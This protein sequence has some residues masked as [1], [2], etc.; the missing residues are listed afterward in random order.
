[1]CISKQRI[2]LFIKHPFITAKQNNP[3][4]SYFD[5]DNGQ[6]RCN[7]ENKFVYYNIILKC[8]DNY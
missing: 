1:M 5:Y 8:K 4:L 3:S 6:F 7:E 2:I